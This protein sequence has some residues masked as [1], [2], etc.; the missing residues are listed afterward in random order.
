MKKYMIIIPVLGLLAIAFFYLNEKN[1]EETIEKSYQQETSLNLN[2]E[3]GFF[4][5]IKKFFIDENSS[6]YSEGL[7]VP[8]KANTLEEFLSGKTFWNHQYNHNRIYFSEDNTVMVQFFKNKDNYE[9]GDVV[10]G[11]WNA[12]G[13][14]LCIDIDDIGKVCYQTSIDYTSK[15]VP[16][17]TDNLT[18]VSAMEESNSSPII[19]N[20]QALGNLILDKGFARVSIDHLRNMH[21]VREN[22]LNPELTTYQRSTRS[23]D[24]VDGITRRYLETAFVS[25]MDA[26]IAYIHFREDGTYSGLLKGDYEQYKDDISTLKTKV[27]HG[28]WWIINNKYHCYGHSLDKS[29][30]KDRYIFCKMVLNP[31][32]MMETAD[33]FVTHSTHGFTMNHS[34][35]KFIPISKFENFDVFEQL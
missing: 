32:V 3:K 35:E 5:N 20:R 26:P 17:H 14:K 16:G 10:I 8:P 27:N 1:V 19:Y 25:V 7:I 15:G 22:L 6:K 24:Q 28:Q 12:D 21:R 30:I 9:F 2:Q 23:I 33:G 29:N 34:P 18:F 4:K 31:N 11:T 13:K